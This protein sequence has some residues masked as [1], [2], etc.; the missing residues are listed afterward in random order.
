M[1]DRRNLWKP[2]VTLV[3][4]VTIINFLSESKRI[5]L[6]NNYSDQDNRTVP[7]FS[8]STSPNGKLV[9][10]NAKPRHKKNDFMVTPTNRPAIKGYQ[11]DRNGKKR[12]DSQWWKCL[13]HSEDVGKGDGIETENSLSA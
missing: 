11:N 10:R 3:A 7:L 12:A 9:K 8:A 2:S 13:V 6:K 1:I 4:T 5:Q